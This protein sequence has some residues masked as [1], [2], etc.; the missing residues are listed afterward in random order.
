MSPEEFSNLVVNLPQAETLDLYRLEYIV[1]ALYSEPKRTIAARMKINLGMAVEYFDERDGTFRRGRI[2]RT[3]DSGVTIDDA[4]RKLRLTSV[5]YAALNLSGASFY[6]VP[7]ALVEPARP[8][9]APVQ[10]PK[11]KIGDRVSFMDRDFRLLS[12]TVVRVNAKSV[13]VDADNYPGHWRVSATLL[14]HLIER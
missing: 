3:Q 8:V 2:A 9:P 14:T 10:P 12:G 1:R 6:K 11:W 5:P 4:D 7:D 13:S